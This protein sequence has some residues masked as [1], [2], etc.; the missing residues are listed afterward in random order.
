MAN[1]WI[2]D[3]RHYLAED[4]TIPDAVA[5][6]PAKKYLDYFG[7]IVMLATTDV[8]KGYSGAG[9]KVCCRRRPKRKPCTG[10][11]AA[12]LEI[13]SMNIVWECPIC[14]DNGYIRNWEGTMYDC[15]DLENLD[16]LEDEERIM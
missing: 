11:I 14:G 5:N 3:L 10:E 15:L 7:A 1:T 9:T 2:I 8:L 13:P 4:G 12:V 6:G 16:D